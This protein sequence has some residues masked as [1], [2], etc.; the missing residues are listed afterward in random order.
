MRATKTQCSQIQRGGYKGWKVLVVTGIPEEGGRGE[1]TPLAGRT[2]EGFLQEGAVE[3]ED[4]CLLNCQWAFGG[5]RGLGLGGW[6]APSP[7]WLK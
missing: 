3:W 4:S 7:P 1:R 5:C 6:E 2:W